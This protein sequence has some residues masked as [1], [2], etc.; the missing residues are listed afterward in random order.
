[1][2]PIPT[3]K[4]KDTGIQDLSEKLERSLN[5]KAETNLGELISKQNFDNIKNRYLT[6][7][8]IFPQSKWYIKPTTLLPDGRQLLEIDVNG[9][10]DN[11][12]HKY[13]FIAK[14][15]LAVNINQNKIIDQ[16]VISEY[17]ILKSVKNQLIVS[18]SIPNQ[19]LTG[20]RYDID[21]ILDKPLGDSMV[22]AGLINVTTEQL[23]KQEFPP[24][25]LHPMGGGGLFKSV[26]APLTAGK[27]HWAA[28]LAHPEGIISITKLVKVISDENK[29]N[30]SIE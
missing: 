9:S 3:G 12:D 10:K 26:T 25:E 28:L 22:A 15:I 11:G 2:Q 20:S 21:V 7:L 29:S 5:Q 18:L 16:E 30:A 6:F 24:I 14:Q 23:Q 17:S 8:A 19:V 4:A 27:Q 1:M 13:S